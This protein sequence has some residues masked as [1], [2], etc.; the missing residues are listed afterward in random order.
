MSRFTLTDAH[1]TEVTGEISRDGEI[2]LT[3]GNPSTH[4]PV[5]SVYLTLEQ[6]AELSGHLGILIRT[7]RYGQ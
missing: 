1:G 4:T 5:D 3:I 6:A 2:A 7:I